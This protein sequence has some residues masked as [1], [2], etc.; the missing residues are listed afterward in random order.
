MTDEQMLDDID[1]KLTY[2]DFVFKTDISHV[3]KRIKELRERNK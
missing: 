1:E 3:R 2:M